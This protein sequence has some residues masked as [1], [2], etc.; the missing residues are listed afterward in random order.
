M[1]L[2]FLAVC[3][4]LVDPPVA[5]LRNLV[6]HDVQ[7]LQRESSECSRSLEPVLPHLEASHNDEKIYFERICVLPKG[8]SAS[9]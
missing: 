5:H 9:P 6:H 2:E 3:L 1:T 4:I 7:S 8:R